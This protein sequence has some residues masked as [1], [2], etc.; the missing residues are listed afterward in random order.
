MAKS[1][2]MAAMAVALLMLIL[3][4]LDLAISVPFSKQSVFM[5]VIFLIC[6]VV[7]GLLSLSTWRELD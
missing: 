2:T 3:F 6:G 5:D 4:G 1:L 7:L